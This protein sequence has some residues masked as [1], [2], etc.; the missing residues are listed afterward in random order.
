[1]RATPGATVEIW[2]GPKDTSWARQIGT[3]TADDFGHVTIP[4]AWLTVNNPYN[5][6]IYQ[7]AATGT[8]TVD[9]SFTTAP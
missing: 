6:K 2:T 4:N 3:A 5:L 7:T 9:L 8:E 1:M